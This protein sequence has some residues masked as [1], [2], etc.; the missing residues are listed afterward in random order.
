MKIVGWS[1]KKLNLKNSTCD[2]VDKLFETLDRLL[3]AEKKMKIRN[4]NERK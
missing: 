3:V 2:C 4:Y 1:Q